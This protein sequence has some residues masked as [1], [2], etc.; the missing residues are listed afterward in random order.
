MKKLLEYEFFLFGKN[1]LTYEE[2]I[3]LFYFTW[4]YFSLYL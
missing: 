3:Y 2:C 4:I 1:S